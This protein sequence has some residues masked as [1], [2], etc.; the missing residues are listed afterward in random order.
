M[1]ERIN[2]IQEVRDSDGERMIDADYKFMRLDKYLALQRDKI[3]EE[4]R[5]LQTLPPGIKSHAWQDY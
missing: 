4:R 5:I 1:E 3:V 2:E